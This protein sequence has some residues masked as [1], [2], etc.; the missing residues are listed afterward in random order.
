VAPF[1]GLPCGGAVLGQEA[2]RFVVLLA[3]MLGEDP[4]V[5]DADMLAFA[6]DRLGRACLGSIRMIDLGFLPAAMRDRSLVDQRRPR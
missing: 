2:D 1:L 3:G 6:V 4:P 5:S